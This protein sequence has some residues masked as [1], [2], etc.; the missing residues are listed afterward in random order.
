MALDPGY[1]LGWPDGGIT[2]GYAWYLAR[3]TRQDYVTYFLGGREITLELSIELFV[4][5]DQLEHHWN[6]NHRSLFNYMAQ[7][8]YGIRGRVSDLW[9]AAIPCKPAS[10]CSITTV[11]F[12]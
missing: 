8:T 10:K 2:N 9:T 4:P 12:R 5:S 7:C 1:M 11:P 6:I 3:G